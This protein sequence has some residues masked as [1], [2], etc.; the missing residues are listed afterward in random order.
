MTWKYINKQK[1]FSFAEACPSSL[2]YVYESSISLCY[3]VN[4]NRYNWTYAN[5]TCV[6]EG[7][8]LLKM[9]TDDRWQFFNNIAPSHGKSSMLYLAMLLV[10]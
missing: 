7:S 4:T 8:M 3:K 1:S 6:A 9:H 5:E 10:E 2:G